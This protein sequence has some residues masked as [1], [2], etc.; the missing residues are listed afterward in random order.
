[1]EAVEGFLFDALIFNALEE[2]SLTKEDTV[3]Q[4]D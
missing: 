3:L 1:L 4:S 2:L